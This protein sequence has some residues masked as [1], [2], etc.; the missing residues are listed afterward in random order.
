M[1][2]GLMQIRKHCKCGRGVILMRLEH[3][4][5]PVPICATCK[6]HGLKA[7]RAIFLNLKKSSDNTTFA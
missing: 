1:N 5:N 2:K 7:S 3:G 4:R 6:K